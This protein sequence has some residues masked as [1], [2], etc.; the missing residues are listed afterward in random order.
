M[1]GCS[2]GWLESSSKLIPKWCME[3]VIKEKWFDC[4]LTL[5]LTSSNLC[6]SLP[7]HASL[8]VSAGIP[9]QPMAPRPRPPLKSL[10]S[11]SEEIQDDFDWD[12]LIVWPSPSVWKMP[13]RTFHREMWL[14]S[15]GWQPDSLNSMQQLPHCCAFWSFSEGGVWCQVYNTDDWML[16]FEVDCSFFFFFFYF[17]LR[18]VVVSFVFTYLLQ[19][20]L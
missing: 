3:I 13:N 12:S 5:W 20:N 8:P 11:N 15:Q 9:P 18:I 4:I 6:V 7:L 19:P 10:H 17:H 16:Y 1:H 2:C 14:N